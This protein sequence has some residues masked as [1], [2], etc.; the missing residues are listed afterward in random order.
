[1]HFLSV[2][3]LSVENIYSGKNPSVNQLQNRLGKNKLHE[4]RGDQ[5][6]KKIF[7]QIRQI[8]RKIWILERAK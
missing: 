3:S 8:I 6:K 1:M 2:L 7:R 4:L 5:F